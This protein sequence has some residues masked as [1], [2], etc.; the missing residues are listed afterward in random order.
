MVT[1]E[2]E[3]LA[4]LW[5]SRHVDTVNFLLA[6]EDD[7]LRLGEGHL[8]GGEGGILVGESGILGGKGGILVGESGILGGK[9]G[10]V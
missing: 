3:D 7:R 2:D 6:T 10:F 9:G 5:I 8:L 1:K 4:P